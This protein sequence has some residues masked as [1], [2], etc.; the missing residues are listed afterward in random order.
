MSWHNYLV[1]NHV[2]QTSTSLNRWIAHLEDEGISRFSLS[3]AQSALR[4]YRRQF[5]VSFSQQ[6]VQDKHA[7][8]DMLSKFEEHIQIAEEA[9]HEIIAQLAIENMRNYYNTN[10]ENIVSV[11]FRHIAEA[12]MWGKEEQNL[13][14]GALAAEAE[15]EEKERENNKEVGDVK[16][17]T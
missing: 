6:F 15:A 17:K 2:L 3:S 5:K 8:E 16:N 9:K 11:K 10:I 12:V 7:Y 14:D 1:I 4:E 13:I